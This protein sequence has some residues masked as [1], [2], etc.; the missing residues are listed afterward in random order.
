MSSLRT[1]CLPVLMWFFLLV[2][3][4]GI[5]LA[6]DEATEKKDSVKVDSQ[7]LNILDIPEES[8]RLSQWIFKLQDV[9]QKSS[10]ISRIDSALV[11]LSEEIQKRNDTTPL[12]LEELT[13]RDLKVKMVEWTNF[14]SILTSF[15]STI[16]DRSEEV[17]KITNDLYAE[18]NLWEN[19]KKDIER[20]EVDTEVFNG[21]GEILNTLEETM[22]RAHSRLDSV[23]ATQRKVTGLV[24]IV[25]DQLSR[26]E[27]GQKVKQKDYFV[28]DSPPIWDLDKSLGVVLDSLPAEELST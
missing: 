5:L 10:E 18:T 15:R 14:K 2:F 13:Q 4:P 8:E 23:F 20:R 6:Q 9:L 26:I 24:L 28:I 16:K 19:T 11:S 17:S 3:S 7:S 12:N 27:R 1:K 21:T 22:S 25:D